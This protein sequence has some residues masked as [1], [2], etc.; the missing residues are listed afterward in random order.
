M[1]YY[2]L[3]GVH[4]ICCCYDNFKMILIRYQLPLNVYIP[5][6]N[7]HTQNHFKKRKYILMVFSPS[8]K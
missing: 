1:M 2:N 7:K 5:N 6:C 8:N 3:K 4:N